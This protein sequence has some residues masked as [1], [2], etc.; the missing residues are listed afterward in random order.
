L[1]FLFDTTPGK[2]R[3]H[4]QGQTWAHFLPGT[5]ISKRQGLRNEQR[6]VL[7]MKIIRVFP[8]RTKATPVDENVRIN[9]GP[10]LWDEADEVHIS[11]AF[12]WDM[13][14]V[15]YLDSQWR[16]VAPVKIGGPATGERGGDFT[17]GMYLKPGYVITSRGCPNHCWFCSVPKRE[18]DIRELPI[19]IGW[20]VLDDNLLACSEEHIRGGFAMLVRQKELIEFTGGLEAARLKPWHAAEMKKLRIKQAFFAYDTPDDLEPLRTAGKLLHDAGFKSH[21]A[22]HSLRCFVL[23]GFK[24]DRTDKAEKRMKETMSAGF[25]PMAMLWKDETGKRDPVWGEFQREWAR[26]QI[27]YARKVKQ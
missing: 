25:T 11:V 2:L 9:C 23:C 12:T 21:P 27:M 13:P 7:V 24:G 17:P 19:T 4:R 6:G 14:R 20:N 8:R 18:G 16:H 10:E 15:D 22:S 1:P 26:P 3:L 5:R